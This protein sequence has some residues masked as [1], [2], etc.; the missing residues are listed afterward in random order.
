MLISQQYG[1]NDF[2]MKNG[3]ARLNFSARP[4][5]LHTGDRQ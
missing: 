5:R 4:C 3:P 1:T 2:N